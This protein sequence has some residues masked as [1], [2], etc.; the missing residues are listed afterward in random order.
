[1]PPTTHARLG[2]S[3]SKRWMTCPGSV[4][5]SE[6]IPDST[7]E[8][9][10]EGTAAHEL[11][12]MVLDAK[13]QGVE[14]E[15][16]E[17]IG[18]TMQVDED[19]D[20]TPVL[21]LVTTDMADAVKVF[22][23]YVMERYRELKKEDPNTKIYLERSFDLAPLNPP[24]P[25][26][27]TADVTIWCPKLKLLVVIDYKH[28]Q[29]VVVEVTEN[30]QVMMYGLGATV[31]QGTIPDGVETTIVQ[32]RAF[33]PD[34][35]VRTY[36]F[37]RDRLIGFKGQLFAAAFATQQDNAPLVVGDHCK[38]CLAKPRCSAQREHAYELATVEFD[39]V[40]EAELAAA[41]PAP[42]LLTPT[43]VAAI[44]SRGALVMDWLREI[45]SHALTV[46]EGGGE[47]PGFKLVAGRS[48]RKWIDA[49][50][51]EKYLARQGL[52][53]DERTTAK[54]I[55]PAQAE[56]KMKALKKDPKRLE[57]HWEKPDGK[58][59]LAPVDDPR[60]EIAASAD[61]DFFPTEE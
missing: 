12:E 24:E 47:I 31:A 44:V 56:K 58:P 40:P 3:S 55:S 19:P 35:P 59:K 32:P 36:A 39:I 29:G 57:K 61:A 52:K 8:F 17:Y 46:M 1:M 28:G 41:L 2:A 51:A 15:P 54:V 26:W 45:E 48:N 9:A 49:E 18:E 53:K 6:G 27:G 38:F 37:G 5:L 60:P 10:Q 43:E 33:H 13:I 7:S 34:G 22:T 30:S 50:K 11:A 20:G 42:G 4:A 25:M 16:E 23:D 14:S 21:I